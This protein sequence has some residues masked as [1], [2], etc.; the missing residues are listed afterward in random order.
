MKQADFRT[1]SAH[2]HKGSHEHCYYTLGEQNLLQLRAR[3]KS[4]QEVYHQKHRTFSSMDDSEV[5]RFNPRCGLGQ[6]GFRRRREPLSHFC[7]FGIDKPIK[8][9]RRNLEETH[10]KGR[11][12]EA[13]KK[14]SSVSALEHLFTPQR[15][16]EDSVDAATMRQRKNFENHLRKF[17]VETNSR[18]HALKNYSTFKEDSQ[19]KTTWIAHPWSVNRLRWDLIMVL[20]CTLSMIL[21]PIMVAFLEYFDWWDECLAFNLTSDVISAAD[22]IFNLRTGFVDRSGVSYKVNLSSEAIR[23]HY[24]KGWFAADFISTFPFDYTLPKIIQVFCFEDFELS[25]RMQM[26]G[27]FFGLLR[28]LRVCRLVRYMTKLQRSFSSSTHWVFLRTLNMV[29]LMVLTAHWNGCLHFLVSSCLGFPDRGWIARTGIKD[30]SW[31]VQYS[32]SLFNSLS[33]TLCI[34]YGR[35]APETLVDMWFTLWGMLSGS[36]GFCLIIAHIAAVWQQMDAPRKLHRQKMAELEDY[37]SYKA[38]DEKLRSKI[39]DYFEQRYHGRVFDEERILA[40]MSEPLRELVM[41]H[42]CQTMISSL[43]FLSSAEPPFLNELVTHLK[44]ELYQP[45]DIIVSHGTVG[46]K[47]FFI[48][49]GEVTILNHDGAVLASL[50]EGQ[51]FGELSLL[52]RCERNATV[53]AATHCSC[54]TLDVNDF[55]QVLVHFPHIEVSIRTLSRDIHAMCDRMSQDGPTSLISAVS[56][57]TGT[58]Y[59]GAEPMAE[60]VEAPPDFSDCSNAALGAS[61]R[62]TTTSS[63]QL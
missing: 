21:V 39:R 14:S 18:R 46:E 22:I 27:K 8:E 7:Q 53:R 63:Y 36:V 37:M 43:P 48:Q 33:Q 25:T 2:P 16:L 57:M 42:N 6:I 51:Y 23:S 9:G 40:C 28:L 3:L 20:V 4:F 12:S 52:V 55:R 15:M 5:P 32:W 24:L 38:F 56:M 50:H 49:S 30:S 31:M 62:Q 11:S 13:Q 47:M 45:D 61:Q 54:F 29:S 58:L 34:G 10:A 41:R 19:V 60:D 26:L 44:F 59:D 1:A 17:F 35:M